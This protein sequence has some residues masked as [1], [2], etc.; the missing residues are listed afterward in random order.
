MGLHSEREGVPLILEKVEQ[1]LE[2]RE[3]APAEVPGVEVPI[4]LEDGRAEVPGA[5]ESLTLQ[6][7]RVVQVLAKVELL[8]HVGK[9]VLRV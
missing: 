2:Y 8:D 9:T 5:N 4:I 1:L 7:L 3:V 6:V